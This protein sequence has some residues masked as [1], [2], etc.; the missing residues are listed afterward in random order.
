MFGRTVDQEQMKKAEQWYAD[1]GLSN[2]AAEIQHR[3]EVQADALRYAA[4]ICRKHGGLSI[5][6]AGWIERE[7]E[8][9]EN[10]SAPNAALSGEERK[11]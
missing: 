2:D 5:M 11:P 7:A 10:A 1:G 6:A 4:E 9:L 3:R 8:H